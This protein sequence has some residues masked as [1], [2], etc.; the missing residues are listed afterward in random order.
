MIEVEEVL[1]ALTESL[2]KSEASLIAE[3]LGDR[4]EWSEIHSSSAERL[5][6]VVLV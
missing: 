1:E 4:V 5:G 2:Y 6:Y 3:N